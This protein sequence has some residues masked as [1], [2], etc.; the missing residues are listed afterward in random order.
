MMSH[1]R[2]GHGRG[3]IAIVGKRTFSGSSVVPGSF[4]LP[5]ARVEGRSREEWVGIRDLLVG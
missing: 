4:S 5:L 2:G 1:K 3:G